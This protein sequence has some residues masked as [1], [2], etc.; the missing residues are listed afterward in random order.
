[1]KDS[2]FDLFFGR[3]NDALIYF[4]DLVTFSIWF[5]YLNVDVEIQILNSF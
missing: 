4:W 5:D 1:M 3:I 2:V